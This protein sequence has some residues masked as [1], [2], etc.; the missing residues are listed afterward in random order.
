MSTAMDIN[1][2]ELG[3]G[4]L[5]L[6]IP[7]GILWYYQTGLVKDTIWATVRMTVQLLLVGVYLEF[8]FKLNNTAIN[9]LWVSV[10]IAAGTWTTISRSDL[11]RKIFLLP[12][13]LGLTGS[14]I[15]VDAY[16]FGVVIQLNNLFEAMYLIPITGMLLG[17]CIRGNVIG[18]NVYYSKL[19]KEQTPYRFALAN[20]ATKR[21]ALVP[22][23][24]EAL[25]LAFN[26]TIA[27]IAVVGLISLPGMMTGQ[28]LGGSSPMVAIKYQIMLMITIFVASIVAVVLT[29]VVSNSVIFDEFDMPSRKIIEQN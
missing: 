7:I 22:Y 13:L 21:E 15:V 27:S 4:Y 23:M 19:Q 11:N 14:I 1:W 29:I 24:Q 17:N 9:L 6:L 20:G 5:L 28:I 10:M 18:L 12:V 26:P 25:K 2:F 16:F 3:L 8:L